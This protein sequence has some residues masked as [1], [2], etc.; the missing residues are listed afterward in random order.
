M[1][2]FFGDVLEEMENSPDDVHDLLDFDATKVECENF[3]KVFS[4]WRT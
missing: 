4:T 1:L 2:L 3:G